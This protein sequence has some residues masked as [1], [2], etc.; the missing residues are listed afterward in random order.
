[1]FAELHLHEKLLKAVAAL[2][3]EALTPV[4]QHA[5]PPG[6]AGRDLLVKA[7]TGSGKTGAY[8]LPTLHRL[9]VEPRSS[10]GSRALVLV[11]TRELASQVAADA[12]RFAAFTGLR[13]AVL[14]GGQSMQQQRALIRKDPEIVVATP[15]RL[16][17]HI[18]QNAMALEELE[19][20]V[21]DEADR[22]F[23]MG[24]VDD[25]AL[26]IEACGSQHQS[27][28]F[29]ATLPAA[30][31][32][33]AAQLLREPLNLSISEPEQEEQRIAQQY[34]LADD[35]RHKEKLLLWLL[36]NETYDKAIIF[37]NTRDRA[38]ELTGLLRYRQVAAD[39]LHGELKQDRRA[40]TLT[41]FRHGRFRVLVASDVAARGLDVQGVDLVINFDMARK[42]DDY[43]HRIGR[44]GRAGESGLA[45]SLIA[46]PEWNLRA[47]VERYLGV[48]MERRSIKALAGSY[49]GPRK[50]K[51]SGKAAGAR[52]KRVPARKDG[53]R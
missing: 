13:T 39:L 27:L 28:L 4:Q 50:V 14:T 1:M 9:L 11:P 8:M 36:Q 52:K 2:G 38:N 18:R 15:G 31:R 19:V 10:S 41:A 21:L 33:L 30:V 46:A 25:V 6:M 43:L 24:M 40:A 17:E 45:V 23:D 20:L 35:D 3:F 22:M 42:G 5:I 7:A 34:I 47:S 37:T 53:Q 32:A 29:S 51:N 26:I 49:R 44:T 12:E 48:Q 16:L